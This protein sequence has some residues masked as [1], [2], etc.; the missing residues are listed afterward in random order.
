MKK[1]LILLLLKISFL[2]AVE[3]KD[4]SVICKT[5]DDFKEY[6]VIEEKAT[7]AFLPESCM[8]I[9]KLVKVSLIEINEKD[10]QIAKI[11]VN[12]LNSSFYILRNNLVISLN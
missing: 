4:L 2:N 5:I 8:A 3:I 12:D 9:T 7:F 11:L 6:K 10:Q 1:I